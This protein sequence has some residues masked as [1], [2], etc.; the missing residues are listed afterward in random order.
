MKRSRMSHDPSPGTSCPRPPCRSLGLFSWD[1]GK[2]RGGLCAL[3]WHLVCPWQTGMCPLVRRAPSFWERGA[4]VVCRGQAGVWRWA[5]TPQEHCL[6]CRS[7][8]M[9]TRPQLPQAE[10][11]SQ[12]YPSHPKLL[13]SRDTY[14]VSPYPSPVP[15]LMSS[16]PAPL[17]RPALHTPFK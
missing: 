5:A 13:T 12:L 4:V 7:P 16:S 8:D 6:L 3:S 15:E 10:A 1:V 2:P 11:L 9:E 17:P 14:S